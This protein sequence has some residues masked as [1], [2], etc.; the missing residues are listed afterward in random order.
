MGQLLWGWQQ[1]GFGGSTT[2]GVRA[3]QDSVQK[4]TQEEDVMVSG[5]YYV[6]QGS[7]SSL[8]EL[9]ST[10]TIENRC[11]TIEPPGKEVLTVAQHRAMQ[12]IGTRPPGC[13]ANWAPAYEP[14]LPLMLMEEK[15]GGEGRWGQKEG[16]VSVTSPHGPASL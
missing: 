12:E 1:N 13:V 3:A 10:S 4:V 9:G 2:R 11:V 6:A 15:D 14:L 7:P 5:T 8:K 16:L